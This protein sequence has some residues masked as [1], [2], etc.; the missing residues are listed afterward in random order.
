MSLNLASFLEQAALA[1]PDKAALVF[2]NVR[3]TYAEVATAAQRVANI[4]RGKGIGRGDIVALM[5]PNT[6][7]FPVIYYGV[8]YA[9][10]IALPMNPTLKYRDILY[11]LGESGAKGLFIW[12]DCAPEAYRVISQL[13]ECRLLAVVEPKLEASTPEAGESFTALMA[14]ADPEFEMI[15][16]RPDD[17][18]AVIFTSS[19]GGKTYG[20]ELSH[21]NLYSNAMAIREYVIRFDPDDVCLATLPLFHAFGQMTM[22]NVPFLAHSTVVLLPRF[23][24]MHAFT[25]IVREQV[26]LLCVVPAMLHLMTAFKHESTFD[27]SS[28][29]CVTTG[30]AALPKQTAIDFEKRFHI[31]VVEGYGLTETSPVVSFN[32]I[33]SN[34]LGSVGKPLWGTVLR[35]QREDGSFADPGETGEV[36]LRGHSVMKGYLRAPEATARVMAGGWFH[37]GD[38]GYLDQEGYLYLTGLKKD[39]IIRAGLNI[40]PCEVEAV[41]EEHPAILEAAMVG[42]PDPVR[43]Q[44]PKAFIVLKPGSNVTEKEL[45]AFCRQELASY[46]CPRSF[47]FIEALPRNAGGQIQKELL[48]ARHNAV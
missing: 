16:T 26:T 25:L 11:Q 32:R 13:P 21:F 20:A 9:G 48:R 37:T 45:A 1:R 12:K 40:Y 44:E 7:H 27:L 41:L 39:I 43:G 29:H 24:P 23:E 35:I 14:S 22:M 3:M 42:L 28:I 18:A 2:E 47:E 5:L 34:R 38:L 17:T 6:P 15:P 10:A 46:K 31:S 33:E 19:L 4:L 36:V 30:G 8:L